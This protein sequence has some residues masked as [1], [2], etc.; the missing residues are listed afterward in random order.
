MLKNMTTEESIKRW[1]NFAEYV[2]S[3]SKEQGDLHREVI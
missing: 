3:S 2:C 1:N